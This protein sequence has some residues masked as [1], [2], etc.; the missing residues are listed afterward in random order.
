MTTHGEEVFWSLIEVLDASKLLPHVMIVG[1]W[2]EYLYSFC[3]DESYLPNL[4]SHDVD[5]LYANPYLEV[6]GSESTVA[7]FSRHGF[8]A[9]A[10][11]GALTAF[12]KDG[13]EVE[14]LTSQLGEGAGVVALPNLGVEAERLANMDMLVPMIVQAHGYNI[15][16]PTPVSYIAHKLYINPDRRPISKRAKDIEAIRSLML[17][18]GKDPEEMG[19][20]AA[21]LGRLSEQRRQRV[22]SV[23][24]ANA[25]A[26]PEIERA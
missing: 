26:L 14:F 21:Y 3:F 16:V 22:L 9:D 15:K 24:Q 11:Y 1:S 13:I 6:D 19:A 2:S 23:A 7:N 8:L 4:K 12:Y 5:V 18:L 25:I 10:E 17:Y 20:M